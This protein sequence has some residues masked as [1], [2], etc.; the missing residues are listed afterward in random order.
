MQTWVAGITY[1][2]TKYNTHYLHL[3]TDAYSKKIVCYKLTDYL[4]STF[5]LEATKMAVIYRKYTNNIIHHSD[6]GLQYCSAKY[7]QYLSKNNILIS[8]IQSY[9]PYEIAIAQRV[10][11]ILK[12][13]FGLFEIFESY[14]NLKK[15]V[16]ES[17]L[18]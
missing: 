6:R 7:A 1:F 14:E 13:E 10:N 17:N 15:Q 11:G 2:R 8:M 16:D 3:I 18:F 4:I 12:E 9:D 5:T